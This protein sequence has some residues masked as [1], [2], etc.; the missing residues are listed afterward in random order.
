MTSATSHPNRP[1]MTGLERR[2]YTEWVVRVVLFG[3]CTACTIAS[4]GTTAPMFIVVGFVE[5]WVQRRRKED[6]VGMSGGDD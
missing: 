1:K 2:R 4:H 6:G 5:D 3:T